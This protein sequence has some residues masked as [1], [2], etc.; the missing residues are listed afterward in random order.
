MK[1]RTTQKLNTTT[2]NLDTFYCVKDFCKNNKLG[3]HNETLKAVDKTNYFSAPIMTVRKLKGKTHK[4]LIRHT[5]I[6]EA[7]I[8]QLCEARGINNPMTTLTTLTSTE[9]E[10]DSKVIATL[11][12]QMEE[13]KK[14]LAFLKITPRQQEEPERTKEATVASFLDASRA[15]LEIRKICES[16]AD[17]LIEAEKVT[18][19]AGRK[20]KY[21]TVY[22]RLYEEFKRTNKDHIDLRAEA[23]KL[24]IGDKKMSP[25][26]Y[27]E[28]NGLT[29][30]LLEI[31]KRLYTF[32]PATEVV[33]Q[34]LTISEPVKSPSTADTTVTSA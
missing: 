17:E 19:D 4:Q 23:G 14:E 10:K 3:W 12:A 1:I 32:K 25:L 27:A 18:T 21:N 15:R 13:M 24:Y 2:G 16:F 29:T 22:I 11:K 8:A 26:I 28:K 6:N 7:G 5:V 33:T 30:E 31:A 9:T 34:K 20:H